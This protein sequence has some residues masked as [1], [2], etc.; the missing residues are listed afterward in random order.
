MKTKKYNLKNY[1]IFVKVEFPEGSSDVSLAR[2]KI[3]L[4]KELAYASKSRELLL[5]EDNSN[6]KFNIKKFKFEK[7]PYRTISWKS[8]KSKQKFLNWT[9]KFRICT[10]IQDEVR[11][12]LYKAVN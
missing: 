6:V 4:D 9:T 10:K 5:Y 3:F 7:H 2:L 8:P 12:A 1:D 11:S